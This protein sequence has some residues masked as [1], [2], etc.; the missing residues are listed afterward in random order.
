M[1]N[2]KVSEI[3]L[4]KVENPK[5]LIFHK[6]KLNL[7]PDWI[8]K[9]GFLKTTS[10]LTNSDPKGMTLSCC[11]SLRFRFQLLIWM[12]FSLMVRNHSVLEQIWIKSPY[13]D[14]RL[15]RHESLYPIGLKSARI[16]IPHIG[17]HYID[18]SKTD[19]Y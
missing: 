10:N 15:P 16:E 3:F 7:P 18:F 19:F 11:D 17:T 8:L 1:Q 6:I 12:Y 4:V 2:A 14:Q 9:I 5:E 13:P